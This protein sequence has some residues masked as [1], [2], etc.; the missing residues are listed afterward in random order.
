[1]ILILSEKTEDDCP[2]MV[3]LDSFSF[4]S[5]R[6]IGSDYLFYSNLLSV[7]KRIRSDLPG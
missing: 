6:L 7:K 2:E 1:M 4:K 5:W 3:I